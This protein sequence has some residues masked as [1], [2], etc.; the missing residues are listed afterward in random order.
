MFVGSLA[1]PENISAHRYVAKMLYWATLPVVHYR[2][3]LQRPA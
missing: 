2:Q 1:E 3:N